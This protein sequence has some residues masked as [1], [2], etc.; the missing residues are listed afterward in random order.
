MKFWVENHFYFFT[1]DDTLQTMLAAWIES[2]NTLDSLHGKRYQI[3]LRESLGKQVR[4][5]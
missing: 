2:L 4:V 5:L 1:R 3:V